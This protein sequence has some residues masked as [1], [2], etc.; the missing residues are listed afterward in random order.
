MG[1]AEGQEDQPTTQ[2]AEGWDALGAVEEVL[3]FSGGMSQR[4]GT[5]KQARWRK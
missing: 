5:T 2:H 3:L 1:D 4:S